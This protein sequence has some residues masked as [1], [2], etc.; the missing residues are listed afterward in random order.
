MYMTSEMK[1]TQPR[2]ERGWLARLGA[3]CKLLLRWG[4][5]VALT[6]GVVTL[7]SSRIPDATP[8]GSYQ[9]TLRVQVRLPSGLNGALNTSVAST[10][11]AGLLV[12]P[13]TLNA[14]LL[15]VDRLPPLKDLHLSDL[16][17]AVTAT[18]VVGTD[19]V[20]LSASS[21]TPQD[22]A[23]L[24][25]GVYQALVNEMQQQNS[26]VVNDLI[27]ALKAEESRLANEAA[28]S[29]AE[30]QSLQAVGR[31]STFQSL[32]VSNLHAKQ[33][34]QI[35]RIT[36]LL[37]TL[38]QRGVGSDSRLALGS[39]TPVITTTPAIQPTQGQRLALSPL[40]GL[41]MGVAGAMLASR[42]SNRLP[43]RG[44]KREAVLPYFTT[45][46]T[47]LP[48][49]HRTPPSLRALEKISAEYLLL[50]RRLVAHADEHELGLRCITITSPRGREGTSTTAAG[51]AIAA[52]HTRLPSIL[53]DASAKRPVQHAWFGCPNHTGTLDAIR[54]L[55]AGVAGPSPILDT[56]VPN[57]GLLP[58][59]N[60]GLH[61][62][63]HGF[64]E[65][66]RVDGLRTLT[67]LLQLKASFI[68]FDG[69]PLL[70]GAGA[71]NL[72]SLSDLVLLV[73]DAQ[74]SN[75]STVLEARE[76]L[77]TIGVPFEMVLNRA[78]PDV[79]K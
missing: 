68:V 65:A 43:L 36:G 8:V 6:M 76:L 5:F 30:L 9:A 52:A 15:Q 21:D 10:F 31:A 79:V 29:L 63:A 20:L 74:Q 24:A 33:Q 59:G 66:L 39:T 14:A 58:I 28:S 23:A 54:S 16:Q 42:F 61:E 44:R 41:I 77:S 48:A 75:S 37:L 71:V 35:K 27:S 32:L 73:V 51:L 49:L 12:S 67:E 13:A 3:Y 55:A 50:L 19:E 72:A 22:A 7:A 57:L 17:S 25:T 2:G 56:P 45:A 38:Q 70:G 4:W 64:A 78:E 60:Q 26:L 46:V 53:V 69:P 62:S 1:S 11:Y 34:S 18:P 40:V 47:V